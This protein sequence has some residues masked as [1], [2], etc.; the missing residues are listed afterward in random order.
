MIETDYHCNLPSN[1]MS[2]HLASSSIRGAIRVNMPLTARPHPSAVTAAALHRSAVRPTLKESDKNRDDLDK[3]YVFH[4]EEMLRQ[5]KE[6]KGAWKQELASNSEAAIKA[7]RGEI[8]IEEKHEEYVE[9]KVKEEPPT[10]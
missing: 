9:K 3:E 2:G 1:I 10:K 5:L 7:D 4:K 8:E 6:G